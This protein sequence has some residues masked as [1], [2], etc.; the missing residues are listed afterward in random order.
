MEAK[1]FIVGGHRLEEFVRGAGFIDIQVKMYNVPIGTW[2][3]GN[4]FISGLR[5]IDLNFKLAGKY[6][7][8][9]CTSAVESLAPIYAKLTPNL[10]SQD[11]GEFLEEV[12]KNMLN[13]EFH[14]YMILYAC[15]G[16]TV[17]ILD[18]V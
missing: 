13:N 4:Q 18:T 3:S 8:G 12:K 11:R 9:I 6:T 5:L 14:L 15:H 10:S 1:G 17:L 2:P 16:E 7:A